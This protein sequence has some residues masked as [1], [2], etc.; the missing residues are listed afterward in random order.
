M[1][2]LSYFNLNL[3]FISPLFNTAVVPTINNYKLNKKIINT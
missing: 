3:M 2:L 1:K